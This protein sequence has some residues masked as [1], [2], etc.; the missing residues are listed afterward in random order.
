MP[1]QPIHKK[2][3]QRQSR[4]VKIA[5]PVRVRPSDPR[6]EH[7]EDLPVSVNASKEGIFFVTR[8]SNYYKGMR[9]FVTFPFTSSHDPMN[10]EYVAEVVR[11]EEQPNGKFGIAVKLL[12]TMNYSASAKSNSV[13]RI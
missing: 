11:V 12:M 2:R 10:C 5:K 1:E 9:V 8:R 13:S 3:E 6:D 7:F 4:R